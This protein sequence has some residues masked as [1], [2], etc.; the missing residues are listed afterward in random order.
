MIKFPQKSERWIE[1][2]S[3]QYYVRAMAF[4]MNKSEMFDWSIQTAP[5]YKKFPGSILLISITGREKLAEQGR[6][7][8]IGSAYRR[9]SFCNTSWNTPC[10]LQDTRVSLSDPLQNFSPLLSPLL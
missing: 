1:I 7:V 9:P 5:Y 3:I 8:G 4:D 2:T 6:R 10:I